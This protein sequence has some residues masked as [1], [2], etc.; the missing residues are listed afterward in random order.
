MA[1]ALPEVEEDGEAEWVGFSGSDTEVA[2]AVMKRRRRRG[3]V[4]AGEGKMVMRSLKHRPG[5]MKRKERMAGRERERF[6]RNLAQMVGGASED[7]VQGSRGAGSDVIGGG[8]GVRQAEKWAALRK[9]IG[10]TMERDEA[11]AD[12]G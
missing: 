1:D 3:V 5:A 10:G 2:G 7:P 12:A 6:S 9:F 8:Q 4:S 11:F